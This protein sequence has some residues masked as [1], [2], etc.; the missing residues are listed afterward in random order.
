MKL[1]HTSPLRFVRPTAASV[2]ALVFP[3]LTTSWVLSPGGDSGPESFP[4]SFVYCRNP[5]HT[6]VAKAHSIEK[7][8]EKPRLLGSLS[9]YAQMR[10]SSS[11]LGGLSHNILYPPQEKKTIKKKKFDIPDFTTTNQLIQ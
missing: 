10:K 7:F 5:L 1:T 2:L 9:F 6:H 3:L 8:F 4:F 11:D